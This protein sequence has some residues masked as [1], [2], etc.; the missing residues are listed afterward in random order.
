M[1]EAEWAWK[2]ERNPDGRFGTVAVAGGEILGNYAGWGMRF[3]VGGAPA[4]V[5][6][7]GDV[8]TDPSA[9][10]LGGRHGVYRSM[11]EAFY[12][13][14]EGK[15][16]FC[17]GFP[18][19]RALTISNRL[20]GTRTLFP[21]RQVLVDGRDFPEAPGGAGSGDFVDESFDPLWETA[22]R[23]LTHAAVRDRRAGQ[24]EIPCPPGPLLPDGLVEG[25]AA[26]SEAGRSSRFPGRRRWSPT[27]SGANA[28]AR[29][30]RRSSPS[31]PPKRASSARAVSSSGR[32]REVRD[33]T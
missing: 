9:R 2:F 28:T 22:S 19:D 11:A 25:G 13:A 15:V 4:L 20:A 33:A 1:T 5:Y 26:A 18:N 27:S 16:P 12:G 32:R 7:V 10:T 3:L 23:F 31:P 8:A 6:S 14:L 30:C 17:F 21:I 29:I 24:L